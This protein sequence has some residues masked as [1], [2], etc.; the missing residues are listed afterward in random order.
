VPS[1]STTETTFNAAASTLGLTII[2]E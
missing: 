2:G 1:G